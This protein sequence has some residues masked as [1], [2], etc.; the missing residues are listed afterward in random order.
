MTSFYEFLPDADKAYRFLYQGGCLFF[1]ERIAV[2]E[3]FQNFLVLSAQAHSL[4]HDLQVFGKTVK[5]T[6]YIPHAGSLG[7]WPFFIEK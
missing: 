3:H 1:F 5:N 4:H 6:A 7:Q 2:M